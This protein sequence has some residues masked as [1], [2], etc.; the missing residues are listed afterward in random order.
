MVSVKRLALV[1]AAVAVAIGLA[2]CGG[3]SS[4]D[5]GGDGGDASETIAIRASRTLG[6]T[7]GPNGEPATPTSALR[8]TDAEIERIRAGRH[9]AALAWHQGAEFTTAVTKG[10]REQFAEL[11]IDVVSTTDARFDVSKQKN[12]VETAMAASPDVML[13]LPVDPAAM[14][15][16]YRDVAR[17]GTRLVFLSNV[18]EGFVQ[19]RDYV[20]IVTDDLFQMGKQ[21]ADA[22]A[23]AIGG[24]GKIAYFFHD[25]S[26]YVTNQ[27]DEAFKETIERNYPDIE[28]VA[29]QGIAD[30]N[31]AEEQA[32]AALLKH[33]DLDGMY[34]TF[35]SPPA[36]GVLSALR[37]GNA[38]DVKLV[39]LDLNELLAID[40]VRG[41][42][43]AAL[44]TDEAY[45]LGRAMARA[46]AYGLLG[47]EA[48]PFIVAP[49]T[50]VTKENIEEG[51]EA[52]LDTAPPAAVLEA[53]RE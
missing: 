4:E 8:L 24:R 41:G 22:L 43:V 16:T 6:E 34:V 3:S 9:K 19:G 2:A 14:A 40:M 30:P 48:P 44:V 10:A 49:A 5:D 31:R 53:A 28:I 13:S 38:G 7:V 39:S 26:F 1:L 51:Y 46:A 27:R 35:S 18:P 23:A 45:E 37:S 21:A 20:S 32:S 42:P 17:A 29:E 33:P 12:D 36:E 52:S 47:K 15:S 11:G 25:A 50:T